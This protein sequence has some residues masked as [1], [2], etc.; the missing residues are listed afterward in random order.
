MPYLNFS[1]FH[2]FLSY[3]SDLNGNTVWLQ[4]LVK[5]DY[6]WHFHSKCRIWISIFKQNI[7]TK[8]RILVRSKSYLTKWQFQMFVSDQGLS[9]YA[10]SVLKSLAMQ[11]TSLRLGLYLHARVLKTCIDYEARPKTLKCNLEFTIHET[12]TNM[13]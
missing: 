9:F 1:I 8:I 5:L 10:F 6:F 7:W 12:L 3:K 4:K 13:S 11:S 2:Q